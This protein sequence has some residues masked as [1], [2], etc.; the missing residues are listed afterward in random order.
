MRGKVDVDGTP[1]EGVALVKLRYLN[2]NTDS[3]V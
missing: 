1:E 3:L 2:Y